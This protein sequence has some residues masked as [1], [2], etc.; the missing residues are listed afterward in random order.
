MEPRA[1]KLARAS[2]P[3]QLNFIDFILSRY[4]CYLFDCSMSIPLCLFQT[5]KECEVLANRGFKS[6]LQ[7]RQKSY[8]SPVT[9]NKLIPL[10]IGNRS[11]VIHW[12]LRAPPLPG[13][14]PHILP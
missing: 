11:F 12:V 6:S 2:V 9:N 3:P 14:V 4:F 13:P 10:V 7:K 8:F 5:G 1:I